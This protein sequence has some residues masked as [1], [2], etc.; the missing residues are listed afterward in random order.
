MGHGMNGYHTRQY[1]A[2]QNSTRYERIRYER[3]SVPE[4]GVSLWIGWRLFSLNISFLVHG[5]S[6]IGIDFF[7]FFFLLYL[8]R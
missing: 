6:A 7:F 5:N 1:N 2:M 4:A 8:S 3:F